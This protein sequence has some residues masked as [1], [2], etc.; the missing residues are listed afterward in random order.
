MRRLKVSDMKKMRVGS[1]RTVYFNGKRAR[2]SR[3]LEGIYRLSYGGV[4]VAGDLKYFR[5]YKTILVASP[6]KKKVTETTV[7]SLRQK[8]KRKKVKGYSKM[9]K[10][11]LLAACK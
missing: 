1:S 10:A 4:S 7:A 3:K 11:Q 6:G 8:C 5:K 2:L 9:R